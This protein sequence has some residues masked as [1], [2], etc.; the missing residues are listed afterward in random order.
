MDIGK[1]LKTLETMPIKGLDIPTSHVI[2]HF[3]K[4]LACDCPCTHCF[5]YMSLSLALDLNKK[6]MKLS[7]FS[8]KAESPLTNIVTLL[9][10]SPNASVC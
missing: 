5:A 4:K 2:Y 8:N 7:F 10:P 1:Y 6:P 3:R 9:F